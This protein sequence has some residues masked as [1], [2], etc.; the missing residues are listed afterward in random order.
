MPVEWSGLESELLLTLDRGRAS[1]CVRSWKASSG[2]R[3]GPAGC[4]RGAA[5]VVPRAGPEPR[6]SRGLVQDCYGQLQAE[7]YLTPGSGRRPGSPRPRRPPRARG[8]PPVRTPPRP[9]ARRLPL[10]RARPGAASRGPTGP[11]RCRGCRAAPNAAFDYGDPRGGAELRDG[12]RLLPAAGS[13]AAADPDRIVVCTGFAQGLNLV[14][15]GPG[16]RGVPGSAFED[17]GY[18]ETGRTAAAAGRARPW[19]RSRWTSRACDVDALAATGAGAVVRHPGAPV[20]DRRGAVRAA[21]ARARRLGPAHGGCVIEDDYDAEFRY[22]RE[23][24][25]AVQG[26]APGPGRHLGTV[27]KSLAPALRLGWMLCP[28]GWWTRCGEKSRNDRGSPSWTSWRWPGSSSP[29]ATTGTCAGCAGLRARREVLVDAL[30]R[31]RRRC[32]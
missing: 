1:R 6:L 28:A 26:L 20:A 32:G 9:A 29:A 23:P 14:A 10:R 7:G 17:P 4:G 3:S 12:A 8:G 30:A 15:A 18:G 21:A 27:S 5:A 11:G 2:R 19:S 25:G 22:D 24:V 13:G 16:R 31:T